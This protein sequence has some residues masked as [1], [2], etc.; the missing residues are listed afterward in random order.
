MFDIFKREK[1]KDATQTP[2]SRRLRMECLENR[3]LL[4]VT[5]IEYA[6]IREENSGVCLSA[7]QNEV[8]AIEL[9]GFQEAASTAV[10]PDLTP[11]TPSG[12]SSPLV[13]STTAEAIVDATSFTTDDTFYASVACANIGNASSG[14]YEITIML[15]DSFGNFAHVG[16]EPHGGDVLR[17]L[18]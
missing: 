10:M 16:S 13:I 6:E 9:T 11:Y 8:D 1:S 7:E 4:S 12:W 5:P 2:K 15:K 18:L 17:P 14:P 3:E